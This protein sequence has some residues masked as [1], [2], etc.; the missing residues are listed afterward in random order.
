MMY[1][2]TVGSGRIGST[3]TDWHVALINSMS[4][5]FQSVL[6]KCIFSRFRRWLCL[7]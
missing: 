3:G 6:L 2:C 4:T 5:E 7:S 1:Q